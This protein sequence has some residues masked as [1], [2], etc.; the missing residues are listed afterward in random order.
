MTLVGQGQGTDVAGKFMAGSPGV[1]S[2][3]KGSRVIRYGA[4]GLGETGLSQ[5]QVDG[6]REG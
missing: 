5:R 4:G 3:R 2:Y 1:I 6:G